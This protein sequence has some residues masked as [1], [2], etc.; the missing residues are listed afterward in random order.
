M[1]KGPEKKDPET[2]GHVWDGIE[3]FNNPLPRWWLWTLYVCIIWAI[4]Y[5][6]AYPAWPLIKG[7]TP[8]L[9]GFSSRGEAAAD[10]QKFIDAN[11]TIDAKLAS[12]DIT[13]VSADADLQS[14]AIN[15]GAAVFRNNCSQCHG[16]GAAGT[17]IY[18]NLIDD[19]WLWGGKIDEIVQT[20]AFGIRSEHDETRFSEMPA[21]GEFLE[22]VEI[23][24][25]VNFVRSLSDLEHD[26]ALATAG[27]VV[28]EDNCSSCHMEDG[29]GDREQGA[30]NL[31]DFIW[32]FGD[33][34][35]EITNTVTFARNSEM[36]AW[37]ERLTTS[38]INA[39]AAYVHQLGGGE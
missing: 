20:V 23:V 10:I 33:D 38:Q 36:P 15:S 34:V 24:Q 37:G 1:A 8:G 22:E 35:E 31:T 25:A 5:A 30:P 13:T 3:E 21:F 2:T 16:S 6:I 32:L 17:G 26:A 14:Y 11:A 39:V 9:L 18:P 29:T 12:A 7:A 4:G 28:F 27:A 19:D